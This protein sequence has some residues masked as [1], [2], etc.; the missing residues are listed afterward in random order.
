MAT[1][2]GRNSQSKQAGLAQT[3]ERFEREAGVTVMFG[4]SSGKIAGN[5]IQYRLINDPLLL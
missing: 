4:G 1:Q 3:L 5:V 2:R